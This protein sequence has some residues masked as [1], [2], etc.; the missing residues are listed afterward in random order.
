ML[1]DPLIDNCGCKNLYAKKI[2]TKMKNV[3]TVRNSSCGRVMFSQTSVIL[4][5]VGRVCRQG[6]CMAGC[7]RGRRETATA[8][9]GMHPTGFHS[10]YRPRQ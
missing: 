9:E 7:L 8:A 4:C 2:K 10:C 5:A 6:A 3:V 1:H